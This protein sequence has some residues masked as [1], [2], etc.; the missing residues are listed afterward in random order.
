MAAFVAKQMMGSKLNAVKGESSERQSKLHVVVSVVLSVLSVLS[1]L[2]V[3]L[4]VSLV[5]VCSPM[6]LQLNSFEIKLNCLLNQVHSLQ[7]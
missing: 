2:T 7:I 3:G 6:E 1:V 4:S 5:A